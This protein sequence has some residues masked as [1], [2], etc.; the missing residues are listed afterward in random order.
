MRQNITEQEQKGEV[1]ADQQR[2]EP[3]NDLYELLIGVVES[4]GHDPAL[5]D[6]ENAA[7]TIKE[8]LENDVADPKIKDA[9]GKQILD[10]VREKDYQLFLQTLENVL[11]DPANQTSDQALQ[12]TQSFSRDS[13]AGYKPE[14][15]WDLINAINCNNTKLVSD[16][17]MAGNLSSEEVEQAIEHAIQ[18]NKYKSVPLLL[19]AAAVLGVT[20]QYHNSPETLKFAIDKGYFEIVT[21]LSKRGVKLNQGEIE[22]NRLFDH[23][24]SKGRTAIAL[25]F[26]SKPELQIVFNAESVLSY[27][28]R[29]ETL[30]D[31]IIYSILNSLKIN[32]AEALSNPFTT[33]A[34]SFA[35]TEETKKKT[36]NKE[37]L[38]LILA[39]DSLENSPDKKTNPLFQ[40]LDEEAILLFDRLQIIRNKIASII[41]KNALSDR[42]ASENPDPTIIEK[43][44]GSILFNSYVL[45]IILAKDKL[46]KDKNLESRLRERIIR[47]YNLGRLAT[48]ESYESDRFELS[49]DNPEAYKRNCEAMEEY[50]KNEPGG[51]Y[52]FLTALKQDLEEGPKISKDSTRLALLEQKIGEKQ[53]ERGFSDAENK[54][55]FTEIFIAYLVSNPDLL[56]ETRENLEAREILEEIKTSEVLIKD[57]FA[58]TIVNI[59]RKDRFLEELIRDLGLTDCFSL[60]LTQQSADVT[61][62]TSSDIL[63]ASEEA[64]KQ[65]KV[66][67]DPSPN[68]GEI[69]HVSVIQNREQQTGL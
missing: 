3:Y 57:D 43:S 22:I 42:S 49:R 25:W 11:S 46:A 58:S 9:I 60:E 67:A 54:K 1:T 45:A 40:Q 44:A 36:I 37:I 34:L 53:Q 32:N 39:S 27:A 56:R 23:A 17:L 18:N 29:I 69:S 10:Y 26:L 50:L 61:L 38:A 55:L 15:I 64:E 62:T 6:S 68:P 59:I 28:K 7:S 41:E 47:N 30:E 2:N 48:I 52:N 24:V 51:L 65:T 14:P 35:N 19:D 33:F 66:G 63:S 13:S 31:V 16:L 4:V 20:G 12:P 5:E 8:L 21:E